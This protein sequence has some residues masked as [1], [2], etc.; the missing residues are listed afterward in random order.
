MSQTLPKFVAIAASSSEWLDDI[1]AILQ[2][3][4][5]PV[6]AIVMVVLHRPSDKVSNLRNILARTCDLDIVIADE[7]E[8]L[9][10]STFY[11]GE[12]AGYLTLIDTHRALGARARPHSA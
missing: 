10:E 1:K 8:I 6:K 3:L 9:T 4:R 7:A 2:G 5:R 12:P 11:I